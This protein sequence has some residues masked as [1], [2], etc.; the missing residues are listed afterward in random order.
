MKYIHVEN[1]TL[2]ILN[3]DIG[4]DKTQQFWCIASNTVG[5]ILSQKGQIKFVGKQ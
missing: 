2:T 5:S 4:R 1:D 3:P